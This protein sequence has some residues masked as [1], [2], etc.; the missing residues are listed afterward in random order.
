MVNSNPLTPVA[1]VQ[2]TGL[3]SGVTDVAFDLAFEC[4]VVSGR[5]KC[6]A[7]SNSSN[8]LSPKLAVVPSVNDATGVVVIERGDQICVTQSRGSTCAQLDATVNPIGFTVEGAAT[9][10]LY[11][12][13]VAMY[14]D[15]PLAGCAVDVVGKVNCIGADESHPVAIPFSGPV[16]TVVRHLDNSQ[17][18]PCAVETSGIVECVNEVDSSNSVVAVP[19][20]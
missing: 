11:S 13:A 4:A 5:V 15:G 19:G 20:I 10:P 12:N 18:G 9:H 7:P 6:W 17:Y 3:D 16:V 2:I 8:R 14:G 1:P